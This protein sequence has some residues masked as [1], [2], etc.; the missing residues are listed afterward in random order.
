MPRAQELLA[1]AQDFYKTKDH[2]PCLDR[3]EMLMAAMAICLRDRP[4]IRPA[5]SIKNDPKW[6]QRAC[7][8][9][10]DRLGNMWIALADTMLREGQPDRARYYFDRI[11]HAFPGTGLA[12]RAEIRLNQLTGTAAGSI[13][14]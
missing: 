10:S 9:M 7:D 2:I 14:P 12:E 3:C 1:Q 5:A 4:L 8:E 11:I 6:M 13:R